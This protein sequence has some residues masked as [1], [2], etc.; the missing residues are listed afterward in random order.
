RLDW[1]MWFAA[2]DDVGVERW[3]LNFLER[4]LQGSPAVLNLLQTNPFP[5]KPPRYVRARLFQYHFS[6]FTTRDRTGA[7]WT[8]DDEQTYCP[9]LTLETNR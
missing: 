2:L 6:D 9:A 1:Q 4:L 7:W 5:D 3:F 8:R